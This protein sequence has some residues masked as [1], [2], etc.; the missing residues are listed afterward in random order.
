LAEPSSA[1]ESEFDMVEL[2]F[3]PCVA[4]ASTVGSGHVAQ[5]VGCQDA[6]SHLVSGDWI[7][8]AVAD[9]LGSARHSAEGAACAVSAAISAGR[10]EIEDPANDIDGDLLAIHMLRSA[11]AGLERL[12]GDDLRDYACT[13]IACAVKGST[14]AVAHIGDGAVVGWDEKELFVISP[15]AHSEYVNEVEHL[16]QDE[17]HS[18]MRTAVHEPVSASCIF[19]D[20]L[21][22][23]ALTRADDRWVP[24]DKFLLPLFRHV[25]EASHRDVLQRELEILLR[26]DLLNEHSEDDK[27]LAFAILREMSYTTDGG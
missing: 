27:T 5:D 7:L 17:W 6:V 15:P 11:R 21:Q 2:V 10:D 8:L 25:L 22:R 14:V 24:F 1:I 26:G 23:A 20:G 3:P 9:G 18:S 16:C 12:A 13:L 19:T 4:S